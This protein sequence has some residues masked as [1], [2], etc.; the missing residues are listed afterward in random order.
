[1]MKKISET[2]INRFIKLLR[3]KGIDGDL[4]EQWLKMPD[5][6]VWFLKRINMIPKEN[7]YP[8]GPGLTITEMKKIA[9]TL[10]FRFNV[11]APFV[12]YHNWFWKEPHRVKTP[13]EKCGLNKDV[14]CMYADSGLTNYYDEFYHICLDCGHIA[15]QQE[16]GG[17][18]GN[19][20]DAYCPFCNYKWT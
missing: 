19:E 2:Q 18:P 7:S 16:Y 13:C 14:W 8:V 10:G 15:H 1:M 4:F 5:K 20:G 6:L 17:S 9:N 3:E 11:K 12:E